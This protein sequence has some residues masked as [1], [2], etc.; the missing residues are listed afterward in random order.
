MHARLAGGHA[1]L[2]A[3]RRLGRRSRRRRR[4][5]RGRG[6]GRHVIPGEPRPHRGVARG[7][8]QLPWLQA[9]SFQQARL[10]NHIL[11]QSGGGV[12]VRAEPSDRMEPAPRFVSCKDGAK[13]GGQAAEASPP[14]HQRCHRR[15]LPLPPATTTLQK[16]PRN[17]VHKMKGMLHW[18][19]AAG[20]ACARAARL[21]VLPPW[22]QAWMAHQNSP[23]ISWSAH[24][25]LS[26]SAVC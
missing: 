25:R 1:L 10:A 8:G 14:L 7:G 22:N 2:L 11:L 12:P 16:G 3:R 18:D 19:A 23:T 26:S 6:T 9:V 17:A 20:R 24:A 21:P 4:R 13:G 15:Q 5:G